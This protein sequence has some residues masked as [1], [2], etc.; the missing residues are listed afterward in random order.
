MANEAILF[1]NW[2]MDDLIFLKSNSDTKYMAKKANYA[3][4]LLLMSLIL[5]ACSS[6]PR[7]ELTRRGFA[8]TEKGF[9]EQ[10]ELGNADEVRLYLR[11]GMTPDVRSP[12]YQR[13]ALL[14]AIHN[15][16]REMAELLIKNKADAG[17][18]DQFRKDAFY[19]AAEWGELNFFKF[20]VENSETYPNRGEETGTTPFLAAAYRG[21]LEIVS[22][23]HSSLKLDVNQTNKAGGTALMNASY[24]GHKAVCEYLLK[25]NAQINARVDNGFTALHFAAEN[26][27]LEIVKLLI[28]RGALTELQTEDGLT[29][30]ELARES[31]HQEVY[32]YLIANIRE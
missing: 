21:H 25:N 18:Y 22:Y 24:N 30:A 23:L 3:G 28:S 8:F 5:S 4:F 19:Y 11:A 26:G 17:E 2:C 31:G 27:Q 12:K 20:L 32:R 9:I 29:A 1:E 10:V 16:N 15:K 13:T 6:N 7:T 14:V